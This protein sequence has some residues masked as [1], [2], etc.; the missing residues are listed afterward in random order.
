MKNATTSAHEYF[1]L[2]ING[3]IDSTHRRFEDAVRAGLLLKYQFPSY[4]IRVCEMSLAEETQETIFSLM[5]AYGSI[6]SAGH[7][8]WLKSSDETPTSF[9]IRSVV[10]S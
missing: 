2:Q 7:L 3:R 1:L 9:Y 10:P 4:I 8:D 6:T 5:P